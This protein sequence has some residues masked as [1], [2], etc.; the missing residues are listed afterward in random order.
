MW[1]L[2]CCPSAPAAF[3]EIASPSRPHGPARSAAVVGQPRLFRACQESWRHTRHIHTPLIYFPRAGVRAP[4]MA[5]PN[6]AGSPWSFVRTIDYSTQLRSDWRQ[7]CLQQCHDVVPHFSSLTED[8]QALHLVQALL[9]TDVRESCTGAVPEVPVR[10]Q[11]H[12]YT[13]PMA[14]AANIVCRLSAHAP[15][16]RRPSCCRRTGSL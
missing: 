14:V 13:S 15:H 3:V 1:V 7:A 2:R 11:Q 8:R 6:D 5:L 9:G 10:A 12:D 16:P 4:S